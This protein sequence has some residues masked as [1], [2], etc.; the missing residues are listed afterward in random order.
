MFT[1]DFGQRL[2]KD[3][4]SGPALD[5]TFRRMKGGS[6]DIREEYQAQGVNYRLEISETLDSWMPADTAAT[7]Q[8]QPSDQGD[9]Y[10]LVTYRLNAPNGW[11]R[12]FARLIVEE[13]N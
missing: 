2:Q 7:L 6:G 9:G 8:S 5:Y 3:L 10:E 11:T 1:R 13:Q 4:I 12:L